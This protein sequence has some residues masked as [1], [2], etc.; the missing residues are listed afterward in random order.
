MHAW[1]DLALCSAIL[2][3]SFPIHARMGKPDYLR[4]ETCIVYSYPC[5]HGATISKV[6]CPQMTQFLSM[7]A[8]GYQ[9]PTTFAR[10]LLLPIHARMGRPAIKILL[11]C[12]TSFLSMHAWGDLRLRNL[13]VLEVI[14]IHARV[15]RPWAFP[16]LV[17]A[18]HSYPCTHG[19]THCRCFICTSRSFLSMH[20]WGDH[21]IKRFFVDL[22]FPIHAR[23]GRPCS[24][25][26]S[27][28]VD[29]FLSMHAW[30][31]LCLLRLR[32]VRSIPIHARMGRPPI[33][34]QWICL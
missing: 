15:G 19:A 25:N 13:K 8:W 23:M 29:V 20:A 16:V 21:K 22:Q 1:S 2:I 4:K 17:D 31:D 32:P 5:T 3:V 9:S 26:G 10:A 28:W 6:S 11:L 12:P 27:L 18:L 24:G 33:V 14:P 30:G 7:L 34:K